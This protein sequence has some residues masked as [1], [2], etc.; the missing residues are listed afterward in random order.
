MRAIMSAMLAAAAIGFFSPSGVSAAP[1]NGAAIGEVAAAG[2]LVEKTRYYRRHPHRRRA[3]YYSYAPYDAYGAETLHQLSQE[4]QQ[5][6]Q[7]NFGG[8]RR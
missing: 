5:R 6:A 3:P 8:G 1:A 7:Q 4:N 2:Q